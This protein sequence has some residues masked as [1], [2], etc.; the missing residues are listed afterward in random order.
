MKKAF[1]VITDKNNWGK[2]GTLKEA[3][4]IAKVKAGVKYIIHILVLK[5]EATAEEEEN[6]RKCFSVTGMGGISFYEGD[7][8]NQE[9]K[10]DREMSKRLVVGWI[11]D[12]SFSK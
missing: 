5:K 4:E 6:L 9:Y 1:F 11:T 7:E 10:A 8:E 3:M 12:E 2:A